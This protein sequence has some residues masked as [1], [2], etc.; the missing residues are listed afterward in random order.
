[1]ILMHFPLHGTRKAPN[2]DPA[3]FLSHEWQEWSL[4]DVE[5][6]VPAR[7]PQNTRTYRE[8]W[9]LAQN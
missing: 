9:I 4:H 1:M 2:P 3:N 6:E 7:L 8:E 5:S